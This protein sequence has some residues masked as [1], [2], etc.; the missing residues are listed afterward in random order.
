[1]DIVWQEFV[2]GMPEGQQFA[3]IVIRLITAVV[4]G[5]LIG[6][7]RERAGKSAG[8]RT[9]VLVTLGTCLFVL[10]GVAIGMNSD[11]MSRIIQGIATGIGFIGA[12][13][14]L[15]L[16]EEQ[17]IR[18]LTTAAGIWMT[19]AIGVC[20]GLGMIGISMIAAVLT[21]IVLAVLT[22]FEIKEEKAR[23]EP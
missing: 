13:S 2:R 8:L 3:Q 15:K 21:L 11:G 9:H 7:E 12:G 16:S 1:M 22:R 14:I 17:A 6:Y 5:A 19:S 10:A 4:I 18:G 23:T 20:I